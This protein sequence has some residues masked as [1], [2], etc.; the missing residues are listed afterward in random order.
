M[1]NHT[2]NLKARAL[3]ACPEFLRA[4]RDRIEASPLG[5][6][7]AKGA[8]WSL[9]G[10]L[11]SRGLALL[12]SI[13]VARILGK[14]GFGELGIIQ[15]TVGMF[16]VFAG[17]GLGMTATKYIAEFR[18]KDPGKA[19]RVIGL[20]N[21]VSIVSGGVMS[22]ILV[23]LARWLASHTLAA[24][25]L[26]RL[27]QISAG[28]L[29][30]SALTG[31][32]T[33]VLAGFEAFKTIARVNFWAGIANF[34]LMVIGVSLAGITGAV[35][36][37][38][39][40]MLVNWLLNHVAITMEAQRANG[41]ATYSD[42]LQEWKILWKFSF[43]AVLAGVM[44]GPVNWVCNAM[45]V[46]QPNGYAEMGIFNAANQWRMA[47][48]FVPGA[49]GAI[50]L[51]VLSNLH[52]VGDHLSYRRVFW[53]NIL[54]NGSVSLSIALLVSLLAPIIM[55]TYGKGFESGHIVLV[56]LS[57][58]AV[59]NATIGV[60]GQSIASAGKMWWGMLLNA[61]WSFVLLGSMWLLKSHG[62]QG[63][64]I[65][66]VIAYGFHLMTVSSYTYLFLFRNRYS[67]NH[68]K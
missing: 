67:F 62:A 31:A 56:L 42:C 43:P 4:Y 26:T 51:P 9:A 27:L 55:G 45:L 54:L 50:V 44:A 6:R 7:L 66:I 34:P 15:S 23:F 40:G 35:W 10:A 53:Y 57:L 8:F 36:G 63:L 37:L 1:S 22:L 47:I 58:S 61:L 28:L 38:V 21:I 29:F 3:S 5:L 49:V 39:A 12:S 68:L 64:S 52:G 11:I 14:E 2:V 24:P 25:H 19:G 59:L 65:S 30:L 17:F 33:G 20:S 13:I 41:P 46:N 16:G 60:I 18:T 48:L 32:Q